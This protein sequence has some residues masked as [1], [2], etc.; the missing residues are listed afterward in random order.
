M[1]IDVPKDVIHRVSTDLFKGKIVTNVY[2]EVASGKTIMADGLKKQA[3]LMDRAPV[4]FDDR[5]EMKDIFDEDFRRAIKW[6]TDIILVTQKKIESD[7]IDY[8]VETSKNF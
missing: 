2:W 4:I 6:K 5:F 7:S 8:Y 3:Q 1:T